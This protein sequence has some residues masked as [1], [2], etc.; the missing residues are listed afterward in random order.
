M[1]AYIPEEV[2]DVE[3]LGVHGD[4]PFLL[5]F[6]LRNSVVSEEENEIIGGFL[7]DIAR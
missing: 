6:I 5:L 2:K 7:V 1:P 3:I 4:C